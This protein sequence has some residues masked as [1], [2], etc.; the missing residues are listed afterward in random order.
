MKMKTTADKR[1]NILNGFLDFVFFAAGSAIYGLG[2]HMFALPNNIS[3]G[4]VTGVATVLNYLFPVLP[5][6]AA[7]LVLNVPLFILAFL[8]L[9]RKLF[10]VSLGN[11]SAYL[12]FIKA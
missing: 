4:G 3:N 7:M 9:G 11:V 5:I 2:I 10:I 1:K 6:G 8:S 12:I